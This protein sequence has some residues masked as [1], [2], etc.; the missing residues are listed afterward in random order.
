MPDSEE[1]SRESD[2]PDADVGDVC[3]FKSCSRSAAAAAA[4]GS[5]IPMTDPMYVLL[6]TAP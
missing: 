6:E 3:K 1:L 2:L 5:S 4:T